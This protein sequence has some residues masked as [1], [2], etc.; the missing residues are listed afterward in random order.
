MSAAA[1]NIDLRRQIAEY[2]DFV[3]RTLR[4]QLQA[5]VDA[6]EETEREISEYLRLQNE[7]RLHVE[8]AATGN[9][10]PPIKAVIDISHAAVYCNVLVPNPRTI[11]VDVGLGF[12]V[13]MTLAEAMSF[14]DR[15]VD[16][17]E[18]NVLKHRLKVAA[19]VARDVENALKLLEELG[20]ELGGLEEE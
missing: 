5:A 1:T 9:K 12:H 10:A 17:L 16:H 19:T 15:R 4:P 7:L 8:R 13:E 2:G 18:K 3:A 14:V 20:G 11:Y 6:R